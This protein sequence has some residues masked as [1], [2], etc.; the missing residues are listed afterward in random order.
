MNRTKP[1]HKERPKKQ[2]KETQN[3]PGAVQSTEEAYQFDP[4]IIERKSRMFGITVMP[5]GEKLTYEG[6]LNL[7]EKRAKGG[8]LTAYQRYHLRHC[9]N[10]IRNGY[11]WDELMLKAS[12]C[13]KFLARLTHQT[14][15][16]YINALQELAVVAN[17]ATRILNELAAS[18]PQ[19]V[20]VVAR[21]YS[22]WP[23]LVR[24]PKSKRSP[25]R[26]LFDAIE[27]GKDEPFETA[28]YELGEQTNAKEM[29]AYL[30]STIN[31]CRRNSQR[32]QEL[33]APIQDYPNYW[34]FPGLLTK[35]VE[36]PP[37]CFDSKTAWWKVGRWL[38]DQLCQGEPAKHPLLEKYTKT[39]RVKDYA[40][41]PNAEAIKQV[42]QAFMQIIARVC[43]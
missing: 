38:L 31:Y 25:Y 2:R 29:A 19:F 34:I 9:Q 33:P 14:K 20:A 5:T 26:D 28:A 37:L 36:L 32:L 10:D 39:T 4:R 40:G 43:Q 24:P 17:E 41:D 22:N 23:V 6:L 16:G 12:E 13:R 18:D 7:T 30:L 42:R 11:D 1:P 27:L 3:L 15:N 35:A 21:K 8:K